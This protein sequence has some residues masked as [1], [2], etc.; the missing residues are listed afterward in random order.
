MNDCPLPSSDTVGSPHALPNFRLTVSFRRTVK[1][2]SAFLI[3]PL[4]GKHSEMTSRTLKCPGMTK[5]DT[6][7]ENSLL[8]PWVSGRMYVDELI[9]DGWLPA[10]FLRGSFLVDRGHLIQAG[11]WKLGT[12]TT[13]IRDLFS[14][15]RALEG[16]SR[17]AKNERARGHLQ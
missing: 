17:R 13:A 10:S 7:W 6:A 12:G 5:T 2:E 4:D 8:L 14:W 3:S 16:R 9:R 11:G 15:W 1:W